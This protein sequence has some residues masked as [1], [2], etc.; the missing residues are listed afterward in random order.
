ME[1]WY[2]S[3]SK[4][5]SEIQC[6][7]C[8]HMDSHWSAYVSVNC[9]LSFIPPTNRKLSVHFVLFFLTL[10]SSN[11][12]PLHFKCPTEYHFN[13][14]FFSAIINIS[15][16]CRHSIQLQQAR[17]KSH[18]SNNRTKIPIEIY[19][20]QPHHILSNPMPIKIWTKMSPL[21]RY[22]VTASSWS[23]EVLL[24]DEDHRSLD[25]RVCVEGYLN[26]EFG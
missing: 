16:S 24:H 8:F 19:H 3:T 4:P 7:E 23:H 1:R 10:Q 21:I 9:Y 14:R 13:D 26:E 22:V 17:E 6:V 25:V 2:V 5:V 12:V 11:I 20:H 18:S 15:S